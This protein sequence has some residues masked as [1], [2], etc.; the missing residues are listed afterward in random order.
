MGAPGA[1]LIGALSVGS[2]TSIWF[3]AVVRADQERIDIGDAC[4]TQDGTIMH[5]DPG[6]PLRV[7]NRVSLDG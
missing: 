7:G 6:L 5:S 3:G 4:N 2:R 1:L